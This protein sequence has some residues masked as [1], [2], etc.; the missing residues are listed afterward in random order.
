[1]H[2]AR[3][4]WLVFILGTTL[5]GL[6]AC[7]LRSDAIVVI[8][9]H[10]KNP[11]ILY[12]ATNDYIYKSRDEGKSWEVISQGM[13]H[14]RVIA[15]AIDPAYPAIVYAGTK[16]DAVYKSYDGGQRWVPLKTGLDDVTITSVVNQLVLDPNDIAIRPEPARTGSLPGGRAPSRSHPPAPSLPG[17]APVPGDAPL[18]VHTH[19]WAATTM[20][21]FESLDGG[22]TWT[23]RMNEMKEVLMVV[24]L[25]IDP[26]RPDVMYAGTSGG[27]YKSMDRARTW[28]KANSGLI[29][30]ELVSSSRALMVNT[31]V[32]D[33]QRPDTVYAATLNGLYKTEDGARSWTRT[34]Q[35]LPDQMIS[36]L[37]LDPSRP[38]TLYVAGRQ[39]VFKSTDGGRTWNGKNAG[40]AS[41]NV[42]S[43][44]L[45]PEDPKTA[46]LGTNGSG[47]YRS[48]DGGE[49]WEPL[50][51]TVARRT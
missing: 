12:I 28:S 34:G 20:G 45:S 14:S 43:L 37:A 39:G 6:P 33:P 41:L 8:A 51:L 27:V 1:M 11:N 40:L 9:L 4:L 3:L 23:R 42:R 49:T 19:L 29:S 13:T 15:M 48:R 24:T 22:E 21:I 46:Y 38:G 30:P 26:A 44:A 16:G 10:P 17:Q 7:S 32:I 47:L 2:A 35:D 31:L 5:A 36:A 25:A 50:P 18:A